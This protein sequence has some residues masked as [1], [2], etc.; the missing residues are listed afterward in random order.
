MLERLV[1]L[2]RQ[3]YGIDDKKGAEDN[4]VDA[5]LRKIAEEMRK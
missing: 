4:E 1:K 2:E 5:L 3:T